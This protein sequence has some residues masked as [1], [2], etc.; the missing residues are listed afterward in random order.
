MSRSRRTA[1]VTTWQPEASSACAMTSYDAYF[2]VPTNR[3]L[4]TS[5]SLMRRDCI[6]LFYAQRA[7][8]RVASPFR[9][10]QGAAK[11]SRAVQNADHVHA[12]FDGQVKDEELA[13]AADRP[14]AQSAET[15]RHTAPQRAA[16][17]VF[18]QQQALA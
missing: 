17:R 11:P 3:R 15:L 7:A 1:T 9:L 18:C 8:R 14:G 16:A 13:E 12:A 6:T 4:L 10:S 2:P 5:K